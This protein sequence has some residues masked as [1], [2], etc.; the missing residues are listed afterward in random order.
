MVAPGVRRR[1]PGQNP[2]Y[3]PARPHRAPGQDEPLLPPTRGLRSDSAL[4]ATTL[5]IASRVRSASAARLSS[6]G[7]RALRWWRRS[8]GV[9]QDAGRGAYVL[10]LV[11][12]RHV[13]GHQK[14]LRKSR[15][16]SICVRGRIGVSGKPSTSAARPCDPVD[17]PVPE[18]LTGR[19]TRDTPCRR[20]PPAGSSPLEV[21]RTGRGLADPSR[22]RASEHALWG[23]VGCPTSSCRHSESGT[24]GRPDLAVLTPTTPRDRSGAR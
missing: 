23:V 3:R 12:R 15:S 2:A 18:P 10:R 8:S 24:R 16:A 20:E 9:C 21:R 14:R 22:G 7:A 1:T 4:S 19:V 17:A 6:D 5:S 11:A 13:G